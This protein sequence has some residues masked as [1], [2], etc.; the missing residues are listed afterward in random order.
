MKK[1]CIAAVTSLLLATGFQANLSAQMVLDFSNAAVQAAFDGR[2]QGDRIDLSPFQQNNSAWN[3]NG[4]ATLVVGAISPKIGQAAQ[5]AAGNGTNPNQLGL[6]D[7]T[8]ASANQF[9][10]VTE[11]FSFQLDVAGDSVDGGY[12]TFFEKI[13]FKNLDFQSGNDVMGL[14][15]VEQFLLTSNS[16][17][18]NGFEL[19]SWGTAENQI[20]YTESSGQ[21]KF[22]RGIDQNTSDTWDLTI[23]GEILV[24]ADDLDDI[25]LGYES[26]AADGF[27][28]ITSLTLHAVPEPGTLGLLAACGMG[29]VFYRRRKSDKGI[30]ETAPA[31]ETA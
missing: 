9:D 7:N 30:T 12:W 11:G 1:F 20:T 22:E 10:G 6:G 26:N 25:T 2:V 28:S 3:R 27:A 29:A 23:N 4:N 24:F 16:F 8:G 18:G 31:D 19:L 13:D 15:N 21:F 17:K 14:P 5:L